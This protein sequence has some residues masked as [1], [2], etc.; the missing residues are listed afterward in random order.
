M[1]N[2]RAIAF[3][4]QSY[5][6]SALPLTSHPPV[7]LPPSSR[8]PTRL[9]VTPPLLFLVSQ[10]QSQRPTLRSRRRERHKRGTSGFASRS[11]FST[12]PSSRRS[13]GG[14]SALFHS[15][16][17]RDREGG[18]KV[19]EC[20]RVIRSGRARDVLERERERG[21]KGEGR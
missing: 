20:L 10:R 1:L 7:P 4:C 21:G 6:P 12:S 8:K 11:V 13:E 16:M 2:P 5:P 14:A 3:L 9:I 15:R 18:S 17:W 19:S